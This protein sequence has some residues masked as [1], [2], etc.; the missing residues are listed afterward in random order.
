MPL[1]LQTVPSTPSTQ[2]VAGKKWLIPCIRTE[3][4]PQ[5]KYGEFGGG[6]GGGGTGGGDGGGGVGDGDGS[7]GGGGTGGGGDGG[8]GDGGGGDGESSAT[9]QI[10]ANGN[11]GLWLAGSANAF[12][13]K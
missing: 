11:A 2:F 13:L 8:G 10:G 5:L 7:D 3:S 6:D 9:L 1:L 4:C 12:G